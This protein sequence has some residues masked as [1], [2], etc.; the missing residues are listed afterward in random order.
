MFDIC[1]GF[2]GIVRDDRCVRFDICD[3]SDVWDV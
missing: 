2:K 3:W 1:D